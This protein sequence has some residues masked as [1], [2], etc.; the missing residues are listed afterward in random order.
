LN[1]PTSSSKGETQALEGKL[2]LPKQGKVAV[3]VKMDGKIAT[4]LEKFALDMGIEKGD[5]FSLA[6][7]L[8]VVALTGD[9]LKPF[10]QITLPAIWDFLA[11]NKP[12]A[13]AVRER[14]RARLKR[15]SGKVEVK[16]EESD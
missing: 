1:P 10:S 2:R 4:D 15:L 12:F 6:L 8:G 16:E 13:A 14:Y 9:T 7:S 5:A 11:T 3:S